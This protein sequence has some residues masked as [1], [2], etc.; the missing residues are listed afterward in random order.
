MP[1]GRPKEARLTPRI[2]AK[3]KD[4]LDLATADGNRTYAE[5]LT[6]R[7]LMGLLAVHLHREAI[8]AINAQRALIVEGE[9][10]RRVQKVLKA[11][12][13]IKA[14]RSGGRANRDVGPPDDALSKGP[15]V[16][17]GES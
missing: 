10:D 4:G 5:R 8:K 2:L 7:M 6:D 17:R 11:A 9:V 12:A 16:T 15:S 1:P 13:E 14:A 3:L